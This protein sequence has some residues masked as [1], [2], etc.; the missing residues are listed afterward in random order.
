MRLWVKLL[1]AIGAII[2]ICLV[3]V[4]VLAYTLIRQQFDRFVRNQEREVLERLG[5]V[6]AAYY[7]RN[8]DS[9]SGLEEVWR[10]RRERLPAARRVAGA[11]PTVPGGATV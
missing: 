8:N 2:L 3:V 5:P 6:L 1:L 11:H 9:W 7:R 4:E 10:L